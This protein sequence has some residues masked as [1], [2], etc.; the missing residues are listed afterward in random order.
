MDK[1]ILLKSIWDYIVIVFW[2]CLVVGPVSAGIAFFPNLFLG[3]VL[4]IFIVSVF[5]LV[6]IF[7]LYE[8]NLREKKNATEEE[9]IYNY[10]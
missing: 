7:S 1:Q 2:I 4:V 9:N 5:V 3:G 8:A 6:P 10:R